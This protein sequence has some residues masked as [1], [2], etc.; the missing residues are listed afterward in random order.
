M[1]RFELL[2]VI[3]QFGVSKEYEQKDRPNNERRS[4]RERKC[5]MIKQGKNQLGRG[6]SITT[7]E[8]TRIS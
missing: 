8:R 3:Q 5:L 6:N 4:T 2:E 7:M 1:F